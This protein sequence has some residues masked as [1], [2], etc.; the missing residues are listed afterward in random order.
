MNW[1]QLIFY[2]FTIV[3]GS[4]FACQPDTQDSPTDFKPFHFV[5]F[6]KYAPSCASDSLRC[7]VVK[8]QYPQFDSLESSL[9]QKVNRSI[10]LQL[11]RLLVEQVELDAH[12]LEEAAQLFIKD[13]QEFSSTD[14][15]MPWTLEAYSKVLRSEEQWFVLA[16]DT[17]IF[18]GGAHPNSFRIILNFDLETGD[19]ITLDEVVKDYAAFSTLAEKNFR[20]LKGIEKSVSLVEAGYFME[21]FKLSTQFALTPTGL[22][23]FYNTYEIAPYVVGVTEFEIPYEQSK[24]LIHDDFL[25]K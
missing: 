21:D 3:V 25:P 4:L 23:L 8:L 24:G 15:V 11:L 17:Y 12:S 9:R 19:L 20:K 6:V 18:T 14:F 13:Y 1:R 2:V 5:D 22:Q 10:R 16:I 7:A